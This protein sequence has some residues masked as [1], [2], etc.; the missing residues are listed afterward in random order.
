MRGFGFGVE[1]LGHVQG[2]GLGALGRRVVFLSGSTVWSVSSGWCFEVQ[3][4]FGA[5]GYWTHRRGVISGVGLYK[6]PQLD[7]DMD[8][9][10]FVECCLHLGTVC[11]KS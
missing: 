10:S 4:G 1:G 8:S 7:A 6:E 3:V 11:S 9:D 2:L 5:L